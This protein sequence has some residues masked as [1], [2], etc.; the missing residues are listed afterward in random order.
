MAGGNVKR[1]FRTPWSYRKG[2]TLLHRLPAGFKLIFLLLLSVAAFF[3]G[4]KLQ[5]LALLSGIALILVVL[6]LAAGLRPWNLLR[7]SAPL[8]ALVLAVFLIQGVELNPPG[9]NRDGFFETAV[10]CIRIGAAFAAGSLLFAVTTTG[11]IYRSVSRLEATLRFEKPRIGTGMSL[12]LGFMKRFFEI[13]EDLNLA[14]E[15]RR[16]KRNLR[17]LLVLG[18]LAIERM[19]VKAAETAEAMETRGAGI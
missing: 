10:F 11:E 9:F 15:S 16:G 13:W 14:W 17:R 5:N 18:P 8:L 6:S 3:P 4:S 1:N 19:M 7:G 2:A 12:M